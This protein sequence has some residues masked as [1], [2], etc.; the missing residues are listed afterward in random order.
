M[1]LTSS[2]Y[3]R[4]FTALTESDLG[5]A[6]AVLDG[7]GK[8]YIV[9]FNGGK[10]G[11]CSRLHKH[12][13]A[14][15]LP[16]GTFA[17]IFDEESGVKGGDEIPYL[18]FLHRYDE[19]VEVTAEELKRIYDDLLSQATKVY[20]NEEKEVQHK[21]D[22]DQNG[23]E[24]NGEEKEQEAVIPHNMLMTSKWIVVIP[25]RKAGVLETEGVNAIGMLGYIAVS[26]AERVDKY[27]EIGMK[28]A[29][30]QLGVPK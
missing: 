14:M 26:K 19:A 21:E 1:L 28:K 29:F 13:Q 3:Q 24:P 4:Q 7:L 18:Y 27:K 16:D 15:P 9:F 20:E 5:A 22:Q 12:L 30:G 11:G 2:G 25:R 6:K 23:E 17:R 8:G 10:R